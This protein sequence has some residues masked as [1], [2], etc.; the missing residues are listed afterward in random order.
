M[1]KISSIAALALLALAGIASA[2]P[3]YVR[4]QRLSDEV[5]ASVVVGDA[6]TLQTGAGRRF[7]GLLTNAAKPRAA[8]IL[9]HGMGVHPDFGVIGELRAGL[10]DRGYTTLSIQ[11]PV[12]GADA[13]AA[14]YVPLFPEAGQRLEAAIDFLRAKG[15]SR[16]ALVSHSMGARMTNDF[17][18]HHPNAA[19]MAWLPLAI[20]TGRFESLVGVRFPIFDIYA[21]HDFDDV[22]KGAPGRAK[23]LGRHRGSKQ[24][25]IYDTDHYFAKK[26]KQ[27]TALVDQLLTPLAK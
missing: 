25:M 8:L 17:I 15:M 26:E 27:V 16:I 4:E 5:M 24:A 3:D 23:V 18:A 2:A 7:L 21:E 10:A 13:T 22:L 14:D 12:L 6:V 20:S 9:V 11:M 1:T 19:L